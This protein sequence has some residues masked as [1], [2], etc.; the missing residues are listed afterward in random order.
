LFVFWYKI[1][2]WSLAGL[3][4]TVFLLQLPGG[5][6]AGAGLEVCATMPGWKTVLEQ[7][8]HDCACWH[9]LLPINPAIFVHKVLSS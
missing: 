1:S 2:P 7:T 8:L 6:G 3:E 9:L 5:L 4:L